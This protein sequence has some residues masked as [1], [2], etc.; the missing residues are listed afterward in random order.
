MAR[1]KGGE[2]PVDVEL[3]KKLARVGATQH[4]ISACL[5]LAT[6]SFEEKL[7]KRKDLRDALQA[8]QADLFTSLRTKQVQL[9]LAG[10]TTML[11]WL[12]KQYLGQSDHAELRHTGTGP[13]GSIEVNVDP[14]E[15]LRSRLDSIAERQRALRAPGESDPTAS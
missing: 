14:G 6:S 2:K 11:I 10:N 9:A 15:W 1:P 13:D 8:G 12:G 4:E 7:R 5:G 3:L